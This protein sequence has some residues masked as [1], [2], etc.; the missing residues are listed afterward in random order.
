M[1]LQTSSWTILDRHLSLLNCVIRGECADTR[2]RS[3]DSSVSFEMAD[4][5]DIKRPRIASNRSNMGNTYTILIYIIK[6]LSKETPRSYCDSE[7]MFSFFG[8]PGKGVYG[9]VVTRRDLIVDGISYDM[10]TGKC[11]GPD[12][13]RAR[14]RRSPNAEAKIEA[15]IDDDK[16]Q[17]RQQ[18][19]ESRH[20]A[21]E[22]DEGKGARKH[23]RRHHRH[24]YEDEPDEVVV[25]RESQHQV[26]L[27][28]GTTDLVIEYSSVH[29]R[30]HRQHMGKNS[31][32]GLGQSSESRRHQDP[33][34]SMEPL[35]SERRATPATAIP[36][37]GSIEPPGVEEQVL[38]GEWDMSH[39]PG[40]EVADG[41]GRSAA[42][43]S[44]ASEQAP[45]GKSIT[46]SKDGK[47]EEA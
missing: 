22:E 13:R 8:K 43:N 23:H 5:L 6:N 32:E 16:D 42:G 37:D 21:R 44:G 47:D 14:Q 17:E 31:G 25:T 10:R 7:T 35:G 15:Q 45:E 1:A 29:E 2:Q 4:E 28:L 19:S 11:L 40:I 18:K 27:K 30:R 26:R 20:K 3:S 24:R 12:R 34:A 46:G 38:P 9:E 36:V 39:P 41:D 33:E